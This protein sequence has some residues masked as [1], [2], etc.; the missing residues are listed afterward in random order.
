MSVERGDR[1]LTR[2]FVA[3]CVKTLGED[4]ITKQIYDITRKIEVQAYVIEQDKIRRKV[5]KRIKK[6]QRQSAKEGVW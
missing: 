2:R 1:E 4:C 5:E 6:H 3:Q